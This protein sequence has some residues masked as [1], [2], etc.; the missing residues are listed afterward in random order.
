[1][2]LDM[3]PYSLFMSVYC[4]AYSSTLKMEENVTKQRPL[5]FKEIC[6]VISQKILSAEGRNDSQTAQI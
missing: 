1:M 6:E 4:L 3:T 5:N 2:F